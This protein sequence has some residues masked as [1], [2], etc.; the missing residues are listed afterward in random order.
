VE[1]NTETRR[2]TT[3]IGS[4]IQKHSKRLR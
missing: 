3:G 2:V 1:H 4:M